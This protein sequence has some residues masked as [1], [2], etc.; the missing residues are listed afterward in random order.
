MESADLDAQGR[1]YGAFKAIVPQSIKTWIRRKHQWRKKEKQFSENLRESD[2]FLVGHPKSGNTWTAYMLAIAAG[3]DYENRI[4]LANIGEF[5]PTI[6]NRDTRI[7]KYAHLESPRI[8]RNEGPLFPGLYPKTIY[9]A[10]DPRAVL[11]SYYHH[12]V[13][14]TGNGQWPIEDFVDEMLE[15]GCIRNIEPY[16][17]RWDLQV[18]DWLNR[19]KKQPV[20][21][22]RY[23]DLKRDQKGT[24]AKMLDFAGLDYDTDLMDYIIQRTVFSNMRKEEETYG[25]ESFPG[26]K[27]SKGYF[28]RKG[29]IDSWKEEMPSETVRNIE[30][31]FRSAMEKLDYTF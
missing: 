9:I 20:F 21:I 7:E 19:A 23:E 3:R 12:C 8:F 5:V 28:V 24:L 25:A 11:L 16:L 15:H 17:I 18:D 10:R 1:L 22:V 14:D 29:K 13:H 27:G 4:N 31:K 26:E 2:I 30:K 6:H